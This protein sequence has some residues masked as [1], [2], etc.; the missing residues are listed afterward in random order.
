ML[1]FSQK[2][3]DIDGKGDEKASLRLCTYLLF[4]LPGSGSGLMQMVF[5]IGIYSSAKCENAYVEW[6][7][8]G[9]DF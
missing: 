9:P 6:Q 1:V 2:T 5:S 7:R 8:K 3:L 4:T